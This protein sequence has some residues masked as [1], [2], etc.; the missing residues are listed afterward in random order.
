MNVYNQLGVRTLHNAQG[1]ITRLGGALMEQETIDA[2]AEA[3]RYSV[4]MDELQAAASKIIAK[5][6]GAEAGYVTSGASAA[7]TL[8]TAACL[9]GLDVDRMNRLPDTS[10]MPNEVLIDQR[11]RQGYDHALRLAGA[12]LVNV[13]MP[14]FRILGDEAYTTKWWEFELAIT[15][16]TAAIAYF[17]VPQSNPPLEE[18]VK[19][20]R[21]HKIP[22]IVD[23]AEQVPPV[24]NLRKFIE[25]GATLV[26][27]SGGK[28]IRGPQNSGILCGKKE[29]IA[30]VALQNLDMGLTNFDDWEISPSLIPKEKLRGIP[31]QGIG[32][33][34]KASKESIVG[35]LIA[36]QRMAEKKSISMQQLRRSIEPIAEQIRGIPGVE[37]E[38]SEL[39]PGSHP[40]LTIRVDETKL[41]RSASEIVRRLKVGE[42][43]VYVIDMLAPFGMIFISSVNMLY[44]DQVKIVGQQLYAALRS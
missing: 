1:E 19:L 11:Q 10:H 37:T 8:A 31:Q 23:A 42:P 41:G 17:Y 35:L 34:M 5:I 28:G 13:G 21:K 33:G 14:N 24:E 30:S 7:L 38:M 43:P 2:M 40:L 39:F 32:R 4:R 16:R 12:K 36:L 26:A 29:L 27:Y 44:E 15:E 25:M 9:A 3:A 18:I 6:T 22:L 20:S